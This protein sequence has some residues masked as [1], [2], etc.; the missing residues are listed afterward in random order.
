MKNVMPSKSYD[1]LA[2][3]TPS[4]S[5]SLSLSRIHLPGVGCFACSVTSFSYR[6]VEKIKDIVSADKKVPKPHK[7]KRNNAHSVIEAREGG[8]ENVFSLT[9]NL[10]WANIAPVVR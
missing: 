4:L 8:R 6:P 1:L 9:D 2:F 10:S 5:L 3:Q 7:K